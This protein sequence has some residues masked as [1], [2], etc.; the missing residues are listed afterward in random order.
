MALLPAVNEKATREAVREFFD[1]EWPRIV[2]MA[3]MGYVD[4]K[5]VEISDMPSARSFGNVNDERFT[6]HTD[7][8]YYYDAVVHAIKVMTQPHRYFMWLRYVR[9]LEWLQI[10]AL[11][12]YSTRRGQEIIEEAFLLFADN[13]ADVY[14]LRVKE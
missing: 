11:T 8:V 1:S 3:D 7:A 14:D 5:S 6:N 13:F 9:H 4:L 12:D 10:E 2:N